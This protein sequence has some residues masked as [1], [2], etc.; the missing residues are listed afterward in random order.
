MTV[1]EMLS[2]LTPRHTAAW[3]DSRAAKAS[4]SSACAHDVAFHKLGPAHFCAKVS[5]MEDHSCVGSADLQ[6]PS[7]KTPSWVGRTHT[8][9]LALVVLV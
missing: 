4:I 8:S 3:A 5:G 1:T 9:V 2:H 7:S 6:L